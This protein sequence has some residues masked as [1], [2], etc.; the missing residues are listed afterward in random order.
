M[1][2]RPF[3]LFAA[4]LAAGCAD[5]PIVAGQATAEAAS[6]LPPELAP[7]SGT[8]EAITG[9]AVLRP[10]AYRFA[11]G[12]HYVVERVATVRA[13]EPWHA[14]GERWAALLNVQP[15]VRV[16]IVRVI[17]QQLT[18]EASSGGLCGEGKPTRFIATAATGKAPGARTSLAAFAGEEPPGPAG[19]ED[20]LCGTFGYVLER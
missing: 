20:S 6:G 5:D 7:Q 17:D 16:E 1:P 15:E 10:D 3:A 8:A 11:K 14:G 13:R 2:A 12:Q 19:S 9:H 18:L 4:L